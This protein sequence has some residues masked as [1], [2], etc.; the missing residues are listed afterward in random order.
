MQRRSAAEVPAAALRKP[1]LRQNLESPLLL[2]PGPPGNPLGAVNSFQ[3]SMEA[4]LPPAPPRAFFIEI[5]DASYFDAFCK[6]HSFR[7][8]A[9]LGVNLRGTFQHMLLRA[10]RRLLL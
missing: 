7:K 2:G 3:L 1:S 5:F 10:R 4:C 9:C 8:G 6:W